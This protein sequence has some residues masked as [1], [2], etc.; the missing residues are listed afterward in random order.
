V[1]P[2]GSGAS[3]YAAGMHALR[4]RFAAVI[5]AA[6]ITLTFAA[7]GEDDVDD[8]RNEAEST[9]DE[10]Q[11]DAESTADELRDE[12]ETAGDDLRREAEELRED[13]R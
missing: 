1:G 11:E 6:A 8:V 4:N 2:F 7:C 10:L 13:I 9:A 3:H 5:A 12:A